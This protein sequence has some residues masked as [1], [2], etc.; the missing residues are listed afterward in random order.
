MTGGPS[1]TQNAKKH[2]LGQRPIPEANYTR[3]SL[4]NHTLNTTG[5]DGI[6]VIGIPGSSRTEP[7][8]VTIDYNMF[9]QMKMM[10][11][12]VKCP[13]KCTLSPD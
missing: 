12:F 13:R 6:P 11:C 4:Y 8:M 9:V 10:M 3:R 7:Q 5:I 2:S 1:I